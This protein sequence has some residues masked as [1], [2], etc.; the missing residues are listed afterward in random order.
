MLD[1]SIHPDYADVAAVLVRQIPKDGCSG[2]AV[3]VYHA[4]KAVVDI[5][6]GARGPGGEPWEA[7]TTAPSFS[8]TKGVVST[9]LHILVDQ[10]KA[11]YDDTIAQHWPEFAAH[12]KDRITIRHALC[13]EAGLYRIDEMIDS[14]SEMLDWEHM[15]AVIADAQ[16]AHRPGESHGYHALTYG[17]LMGGLIEAIAGKPLE[18]VL[19]EELVDPLELDGMFIG[20]PHNELY[21]RAYMVNGKM[22]PPREREPWQERVLGWT[23]TG[24]S[25]V[26]VDLAEFRSALMPFSEE[27]D[28]NDESTV[29]AKIPAANG[30]FTARSL[31]RM[32]AMLAGEGALDGVRVLS[33]KTVRELASIQNNTRD[34]VLFLPMKWRLGYHRAFTLGATAPQAF[35]HYG[36]GGS[37]G[38][39]DLQR[40]LAVGFTVNYGAG[41]P[42]GDSRMPRIARSAIR[43]VDRISA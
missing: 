10:G 16:P 29:R 9:L 4:G 28:W 23:E 1:G 7:T 2:A 6:G 20:M 8:T 19:Q 30:Q 17:W 25:K 38:F 18:T 34:K 26:G 5:W 21:R 41:T 32:Y 13:H 14:P 15:K 37:G 39:C 31:A 35:G 24:L 33:R 11:G 22:K 27:F 12:G 42:T 3:C 43:A 36:Y 40:D